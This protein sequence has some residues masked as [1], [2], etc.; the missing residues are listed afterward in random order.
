MYFQVKVTF[1]TEDDKGK[2]KKQN[3]LYLLDAISV[4]DAETQTVAYLRSYDEY[5]KDF[6]IK[7]ASESKIF[8]VIESKPKVKA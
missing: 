3:V 4:T 5:R 7:S 1:K 2:I 8:K 6:E